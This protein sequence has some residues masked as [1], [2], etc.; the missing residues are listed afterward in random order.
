MNNSPNL[1][2]RQLRVLLCLVSIVVAIAGCSRLSAPPAP[3]DSSTQN[4]SSSTTPVPASQNSATAA[5]VHIGHQKRGR[6]RTAHRPI[7]PIARLC[8]HIE[9]HPAVE[10]ATASLDAKTVTVVLHPGV[11]PGTS[12]DVLDRIRSYASEAQSGIPPTVQ[13]IVVRRS[14]F[15]TKIIRKDAQTS[16]DSNNDGRVTGTITRIASGGWTRS[17][18][19]DD[20]SAGIP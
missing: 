10:T 3:A 19:D 4:V 9:L 8:R 7:S 17:E 1:P 5:L 2:P 13:K 15:D 14:K 12:D 18:P 20:S 16:S 11:Q 6:R